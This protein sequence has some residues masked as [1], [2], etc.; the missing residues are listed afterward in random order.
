MARALR[1]LNLINTNHMSVK[2]HN[3]E[4]TTTE[5][6]VFCS[7]TKDESWLVCLCC[8]VEKRQRELQ[9]LTEPIAAPDP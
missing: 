4:V 2:A 5:E 7:R 3:R 6:N 1:L 8:W 9:P